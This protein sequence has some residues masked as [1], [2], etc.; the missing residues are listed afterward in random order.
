M[1]SSSKALIESIGSLDKDSYV[2][3]LSKLIGESKFVQN[4]PPELIPQEDLIVKHVLDSLRPYS[5]ETGGGPLVI[6][7]VAYHSGRGNL[8]VEYPGSVPGKILSFVGMHMDVVTANPDD[9]EFDPFSLSIDGDKLRGRGTT[10][11][12]GHV[13]L[14]TELM[15]K[16]GQ[17]KPALKSTVVAVFI[18]SE[19]NSSIP[20]V[21]VDMLV[22]D[23][24]LD[25]LK[26]GPLLVSILYWIDTADKQPCVGTGGM[27]P[28]KLQFTGKLFH[29]G[30]AHKAINAMELAME[31]LKEIQAR[32]YRDFP[33]HPQ[34]EV[35]GFATPS[36]MKPTQ[37]CYPA[38]GINQIPGECTVSGDVRLTP[39]YDVKE[40][41]TK[42]QEY[43]DDIN[44]NIERLETRG[45][46]SKYV[47]P[48]EN[49]RG[50]LTLSFDEASAGVACNLDSPGFHVLCKA[51][52]EVVGHVKP[53][54]IT[55]TLPLIRDLQDEGFDVQ[56]SGYG[57]MATYHAK[58]EY[59]LL[60]DM[61]QGFDVFIRIISQLEQV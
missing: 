48:D 33:P 30:L 11:C 18:A 51:T 13:A 24:L 50:R 19:E 38:G 28:W 34:E 56:T 17:A 14:V 47:L 39:F 57:L 52:E 40:V 1:A 49:L 54:S 61:C 9:W 37:W 25:K 3:L 5:T 58:N 7:H 59:C 60:T 6:N 36:T 31:G 2:S 20:G 53:Y 8:I 12:L 10:D 23:K 16:L 55:G 26:S 4:N 29:S 21:G 27:I 45:P 15:K 42:L 43:V 44:G 22:K 35:Y 32:F 46:V 41:I